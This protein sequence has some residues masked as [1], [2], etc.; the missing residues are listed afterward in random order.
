MRFYCSVWN[1]HIR[2]MEWRKENKIK[3]RGV[4]VCFLEQRKQTATLKDGLT[5][6]TH[7]LCATN[8]KAIPTHSAA[9]WP[10]SALVMDNNTLQ[11]GINE[12]VQAP[13][14][15]GPKMHQPGAGEEEEYRSDRED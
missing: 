10:V 6:I 9:D 14:V 5:S 15:H 4:A 11:E 3:K 13:Y 1:V 2:A 12:E 8:C 7:K